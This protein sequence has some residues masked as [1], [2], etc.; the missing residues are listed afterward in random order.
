MQFLKDLLPP[1]NL[2]ERLFKLIKNY[3]RENINHAYFV[4]A[5]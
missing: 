3:G 2:S 4:A 5:V 1:K